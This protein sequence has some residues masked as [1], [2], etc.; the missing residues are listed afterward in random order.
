MTSSPLF[1]AIVLLY[2]AFILFKGLRTGRRVRNQEDFL[3]AGRSVPWPLLLAT[4]AATIVG[5]GF[6]I[7]A[8]GQTYELGVAMLL[9]SAGGYLQ[10]I[11]SGLFIAP[12][13]RRSGVYTVAGYFGFR[14]NR[15]A[16]LVAFLLSLLFSIGVLGAQMVAFGK[17]ITAMIP[18]VPYT[19]AVII[20]AAL[21]ILYS[22]VGGL[23]AVI[24]TDVYQF[25]FLVLG[26]GLTVLLTL[27]EI[28]QSAVAAIPSEF[29]SPEAGK[30]WLWLVSMFF[31]FLL[32]ETFA[33]GYATRF[34]VGK[35]VRDTK[36]GIV[37]AGVF[38]LLFF[39]VVIYFIGTF[40]R[41][42]LP[43]IDPEMALPATVIALNNPI[44]AGLI[45]A[46]LMSAVMSSADSILNSAT[47]IIT[48]DFW[49][50]YVL[51]RRPESKSGL[52]V[53]RLGSLLLGI[54][55]LILAIARPDVIDL[56]LL[57]YSLW[58]P[59]IIVPVVLGAM[60]QGRS[61]ALNRRIVLTMILSII[62]TIGF[63]YS[64]WSQTIQPGVAGVALSILLY[65]LLR[66]IDRIRGPEPAMSAE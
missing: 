12:A 6:S 40:A 31:A 29:F 63:M 48:K 19:T 28:D 62:G 59:G 55:G 44:V 38:L 39:P 15:H 34:C 25:I 13:F 24:R 46:A 42:N 20:G 41:A 33:P 8:V 50:E 21:V 35:D 26:F 22:T 56:L 49:E 32:G 10:L 27:P 60:S 18:E 57:T 52:R 43:G 37:G 11:F 23:M 2:F 5:G 61:P 17:I 66:S 4:M 58:A 54:G 65:G 51:P 47:A 14:F 30:G 1:Y 45:V 3:L 64:P 36:R 9:I 53:A 16:R 7:G